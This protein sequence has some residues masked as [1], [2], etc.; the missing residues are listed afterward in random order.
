MFPD[1]SFFGY[2]LSNF[3]SGAEQLDACNLFH[4]NAILLVEMYSIIMAT[5]KGTGPFYC[6]LTLAA[7]QTTEL[8]HAVN[9]AFVSNNL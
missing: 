2:N 8:E 1:C 3:V 6:H 5:R 4:I 7:T 9:L